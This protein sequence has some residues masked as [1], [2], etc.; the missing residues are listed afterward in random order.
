LKAHLCEMAHPSSNPKD[1]TYEIT[2]YEGFGWAE[3]SRLVIRAAGLKLENLFVDDDTLPQHKP[4]LLFGQVPRLR[5][6]DKDGKVAFEIVQSR[7]IVKYLA[8][9][10]GFL[11]KT[12]EETAQIEQFYEAIRDSNEVPSKK[13][14]SPDRKT[15]LAE[16]TKQD[17]PLHKECK[18]YDDFLQK[19]NTGYLVLNHLT[20]A[21]LVLFIFSEEAIIL[22]GEESFSQHKHLAAHY[23]KIAAIP[24]VKAYINDSSRPKSF[25]AQPDLY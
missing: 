25:Y 14:W 11:G 1:F 21:D 6:K 13:W 18:K 17:G 19:N 8:T 5:V 15:L 22:L 9:I 3:Q 7:A 24:E 16:V 20:L 4:Q 10:T 12:P 2:Y 23:H